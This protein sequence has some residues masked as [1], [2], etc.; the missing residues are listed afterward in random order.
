V[1]RAITED[2]SVLAGRALFVGYDGRVYQL[3][4]YAPA[5]RWSARAPAAEQAISS[6]DRLTDPAALA[7]QPWRLQVVTLTQGMT[8]EEFVRRYPSPAPAAATALVNNV[9]ADARFSAGALRK[10]IVGQPLP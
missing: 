2:S 6:F 5:A 9:D 4:A 7:A 8:L 10:R 1:F 3:L